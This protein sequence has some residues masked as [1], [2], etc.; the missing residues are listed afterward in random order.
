MDLDFDVIWVCE[1]GRFCDAV[2][3][4]EANPEKN[5][6]SYNAMLCGYLGIGDFMSA[7]KMLDKMDKKHVASWNAMI[8]GYMK[9]G[10]I[11]ETCELF[12]E[13]PKR[14]EVSYTIM[15]LGCVGVSKF[16][17]AWRWFVD[18]RRRGVMLDQKMFLVVLSVVIGLDNV[19][20]LANLVTLAMKVGYNEDVVLG[21]GIL[22]AFMRVGNFDMALRD[23]H[24]L[25]TG[26]YGD[27]VDGIVTNEQLKFEMITLYVEHPRPIEP[28]T[29][30]TPPSPQPLKLTKKEQKKLQT[31]RR[32]A[33]D[34]ERQEMIRQGL[35]EP[36]KPKVKMS[37]LM[38]VLGSE[39][40]Q[41]PTKLEMDIR[42]TAARCEQ[43]H[44]DMNIARKL[45]PEEHP[46][47]KERELFDDPNIARE[48]IVSVYKM[49]DLSHPLTRFKVDVNAQ[50][51]CLTGCAV[52][53]EGVSVF[54]VEGGKKSI[55]QYG[56]L[57]LRRIDWV[58]A[59]KKEDDEVKMTMKMM[60][61]SLSTK[62]QKLKADRHQFGTEIVIADFWTPSDMHPME[63]VEAVD[64]LQER[65]KVVPGNDYLNMTVQK[66]ATLFFNIFLY[67]ALASKKFL[68]AP[69]EII[70][71]VA[72][73]T[74]GEP[75]TQMT[76]N[77]FNYAGV[78]AKNVML[79]VP[80]LREII[81]V[82]KKIKTFSLSVY[83]KLGMST[84]IGEDIEFVKSYYEMTDEGI[85]P[86][87]ISSWLL[88]IE[89]NREM[90]V[91]MKL[92]MADIA[93]K[94]NL[95]FG[96]DLTCIFNDDN[97]EKL[98]LQIRIMNDEAPKGELDESPED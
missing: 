57:I 18:M 58:A 72:A 35:V 33:R 37:N 70:G 36:P 1:N 89:L 68:V 27:V 9:V 3:V 44:V 14:N 2:D 11:R 78:S 83:L 41:H 81:N 91:D 16:E 17:K 54:V 50:E 66:Y 55:K 67:S 8:N 21:T 7:W 34:K 69:G 82:T 56:K 88:R 25:R 49:N 10:R 32:L 85:D 31:Q 95:E 47:K 42:S 71:C 90:M 23:A 73:Q 94:I 79:G 75:V 6:V 62:V 87:K 19:V 46:E 97:A 86:D 22:N 84:L 59:G 63:I 20:T 28:P 24:L 48:T 39:A 40:T 51:N 15:I 98:I 5:V 76:L 53:S 96:D 60:V 29:E 77:T 61:I 45:T 12:D 38:K 43:A 65:L 64:K 93:E 30:P 80:R 4:F 26:T 52:I 92:S 13:M 74:I